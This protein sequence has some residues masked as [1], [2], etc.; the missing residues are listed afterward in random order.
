MKK[1]QAG[2]NTNG[3]TRVPENR[4]TETA[5]GRDVV[6]DVEGEGRTGGRQIKV[7]TLRKLCSGCCGE[8]EQSSADNARKNGAAVK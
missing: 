8:E 1:T 2:R 5:R 3:E 7:F 6:E 4:A